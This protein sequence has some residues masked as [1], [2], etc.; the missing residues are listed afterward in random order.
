MKLILNCNFW[1][2]YLNFITIFI[3]IIC[4]KNLLHLFQLRD[5]NAFRYLSY[6]NFK[7][8]IFDAFFIGIFVAQILFFNFIFAFLSSLICLIINSTIF[9]KIAVGNK[10]PIVFTPRLKRIYILAIIILIFPIIFKFGAIFSIILI[11]FAP[12]FANYLNFFDKIKN[13]LFIK[14]AKNKLKNSH[15]LVIAITGSNGKTTVKN[16]LFEMLKIDYKV[17]ASP[18]SFNTPIGLSKFLNEAD[19]NVDFVILEY[20]ARH[21]NDVQKLC[22]IFGADFG[23]ITEIAPQHLQTFKTVENIAKAKKRLCEYL[24]QNPC[25]YNIDNN[26]IFDMYKEKQGE[27]FSVS[28]KNKNADF[29]ASNIV[30]KDFKT[31]FD[32]IFENTKLNCITPLLGEHNVTDILLATALAKH[33]KISNKNLQT[34]IEHLPF[35]AHRL[36]YIKSSV[37][38]L[39]DSYNCSLSS[40]KNS[41]NVLLNC[42]GKKMVVTPGIIEGG[43]QQENI[44]FNLGKMLAKVDIVVIV[45]KTNKSALEKGIL[46]QHQIDTINN[47][48][49]NLS[50][51]KIL[52]APNL[53]NAKQYFSLLNCN[54]TLLLLNDLPDDFN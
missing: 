47:D 50:T 14:K 2:F 36:E 39:D 51:K 28:T 26:Y 17:L 12:I 54:D 44:N 33:L 16:I 18:K 31:N 7:Y 43:K 10:T 45:G 22:K 15:A 11:I 53:E 20:G 35:V 46:F 42:S 9:C 37:N 29:F 21:K 1:I 32:L 40:A 41:I 3:N 30:V 38:I 8:W 19:L 48:S 27:K 23:I 49:N 13:Y 6:F 52:F 5:Y 25:V 4:V 34:T 24:K